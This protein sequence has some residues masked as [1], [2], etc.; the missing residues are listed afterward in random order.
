MMGFFNEARENC[1]ATL[2]MKWK[3]TN[4]LGTLAF[5]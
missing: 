4:L 1:E 5:A 3:G 2:E